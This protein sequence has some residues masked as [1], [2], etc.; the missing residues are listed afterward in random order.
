MR[1]TQ[2]RL[3]AALSFA[4]F[5]AL[6]MFVGSDKTFAAG[7]SGVRQSDNCGNVSEDDTACLQAL[8]NGSKKVVLPRGRTFH[9]T[10]TIIVR[11]AKDLNGNGATISVASH[12]PAVTVS[13][14]GAEI[15]GLTLI[16]AGG[17]TDG[18]FL[19]R[20]A[21]NITIRD[22]KILGGWR[23][24]ILFGRP[25]QQGLKFLRNTIRPL[26]GT[27]LS[28][29]ILGNPYMQGREGPPPK[30]IVI[31]GN[32]ITDVSSDAIELNSPK[33]TTI[34]NVDIVKNKLSAPHH[35][36]PAAGFCIGMAGARNIR[37]FENVI[38]DCRWQAV[39]VEDDSSQIVIAGNT[40]N[41]TIGGPGQKYSAGI[42]LLNSSN[43]S[44][45]N[46]Q[47]RNTANAGIDLI[48]N[49]RGV[50]KN[51]EI[52]NNDIVN[53]GGPGIRVGGKGA[54]QGIVVGA[55]RGY[56][57]NRIVGGK[58]VPYAS[59]LSAIRGGE[60]RRWACARK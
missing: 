8:V 1:Y 44:I 36:S 59:C 32:R 22:N 18:F 9:I 3:A 5:S 19:D 28:Y 17:A 53:P 54:A 27:V 60:S 35:V 45:Y 55:V 21:S 26:Q 15:Y 16:G 58:D 38:S 25:G 37:V 33:G 6:L 47:I 12:I 4:A 23:E 57:D 50:N 29:G 46:N 52:M 56:A 49:A 41:K 2:H 43:I 51:V 30:D 10:K 11:G 34:S 14:E 24:G 39:H 42:L 31:R 40:I 7:A 13:G 48:W 20:G